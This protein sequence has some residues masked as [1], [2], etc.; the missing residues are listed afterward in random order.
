LPNKSQ[1]LQPPS[2]RLSQLVLDALL[3]RKW[4]RW[5]VIALIL[6]A[7]AYLAYLVRQVWIP[8]AIA[9]VIAMVLDPS[10]DRLERRGWSRLA[11][12]SLIF[13][14]FVLVLTTALFFTVP[15][16]AKEGA[17]IQERFDKV[18]PDRS[19][20]GIRK[21]LDTT[22]LSP[23]TKAVVAKA[24]DG[25][26]EAGQNTARWLST[27]TLEVVTNLVWLVII[28]IVAFYALKDFHLILAKGLLLVPK[29][30][31]EFVQTMM[32]ETTAIFGKYMRGILLVSFLNG[33]TTYFVLLILGTPSALMLGILAAVLYTIPYVGAVLTVA[34]IGGVAFVSKGVDFMI[35]NVAANILL[36]QVLFDNV[37]V[38]RILGG[39]V[40]LHPILAIFAL[41]VGNVL[42]GLVGMIIAVPVAAC[43]Q[44]A[45]VAMV[46]KLK[47]EVD[48][49]E[50]EDDSV[51]SLA[52][53]TREQHE[54][55]DATE[56]L[57]SAVTEA[58]ENIEAQITPKKEPRKKAS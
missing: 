4:R 52:S 21:L 9:F 46:P 48:I 47:E 7:V 5:L 27:H 8:L 31:R 12:T 22:T 17:A 24:A 26:I 28:P 29:H 53:K 37:I 3:E 19:P 56:E 15:I 35:L 39:H 45:I 40:G 38:P 30:R 43:I 16:L 55:V 41:L 23:P 50:L 49:P 25:V 14:S 34:A 6:V 58:V 57:H 1:P 18:L 54:K 2:E 33:L 42:L 36:H 13:A 11:G 44:I 20:E 32:S 51:E 10:V